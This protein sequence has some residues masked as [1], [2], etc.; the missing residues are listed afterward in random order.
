MTLLELIPANTVEKFSRYII[1][2]GAKGQER[3]FDFQAFLFV[4][5]CLIA[6]LSLARTNS[7]N[8]DP[9]FARKLI[10]GNLLFLIVAIAFMTISRMPL[11]VEGYL[12]PDEA[13]WIAIAKTVV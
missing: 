3:Y 8:P 5:L 13:L 10:N 7:K 9:S 11:V 12:N 1:D 2:L 4:I 6:I